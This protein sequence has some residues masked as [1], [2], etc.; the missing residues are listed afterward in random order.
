MRVLGKRILVKQR[1][2]ETT[3]K[4][5]ITL[6]GD[7]QSLPFGEVVQVGSEA[8]GKGI[9]AGHIVLFNQMLTTPVGVLDHHVLVELD[10]VLAVLTDEEADDVGA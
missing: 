5:G 4:G 1:L 3:S 10:D 9:V 6:P 7:Q 2:T 8:Q